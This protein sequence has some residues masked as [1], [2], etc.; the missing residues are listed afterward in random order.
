[1]QPLPSGSS[2][3]EKGRPMTAG[4]ARCD[5]PEDGQRQFFER[6]QEAPVGQKELLEGKDL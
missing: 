3:A 6:T 2:H 5:K 4:T 1:M